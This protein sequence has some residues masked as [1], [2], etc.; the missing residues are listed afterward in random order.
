MPGDA[1]NDRKLPEPGS[2][3]VED[4]RSRTPPHGTERRAPEPAGKPGSGPVDE[5]G[6]ETPS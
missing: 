1:M 2:P 6:I 5:P 4:D 3:P